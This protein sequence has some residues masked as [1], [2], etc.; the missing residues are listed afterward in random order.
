MVSTIGAGYDTVDVAECTRRGIVVVHQSGGASAQ[1]V[2]EH[3][4]AMMLALGKRIGEADRAM[5][6]TSN[7]GPGGV[8]GRNMPGQAVGPVGWEISVWA[9]SV[10]VVVP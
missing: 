1:A 6:R 7:V 2:A 4:L 5:R 9:R 10:A 3:T 8:V